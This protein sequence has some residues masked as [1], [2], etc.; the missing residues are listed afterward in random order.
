MYIVDKK[1]LG[2]YE[3]VP[4]PKTFLDLHISCKLSRQVIITIDFCWFTNQNCWSL[5]LIV[6]CKSY[7]W[8]NYSFCDFSNIG[9]CCL[10]L[11]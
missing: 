1:N 6:D 8:S 7:N 11:R 5:Y 10:R 9:F 2:Q 4:S 3:N